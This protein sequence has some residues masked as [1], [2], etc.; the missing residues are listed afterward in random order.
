MVTALVHSFG[1]IGA[2]GLK[3]WL[4]EHWLLLLSE[5]SG[6]LQCV[7][8]LLAVNSFIMFIGQSSSVLKSFIA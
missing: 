8:Y 2:L 5:L 4:A 3:R 6:M 1:T 7:T